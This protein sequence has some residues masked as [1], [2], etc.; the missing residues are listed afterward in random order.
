[1][2]GF[3]SLEQASVAGWGVT[4][5][6]L[7]LQVLEAWHSVA[8]QV[9]GVPAQAPDVQLSLRVQGSLSSQPVPS[10]RFDQ[11]VRALRGLQL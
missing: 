8:V 9:N 2:Q 1:V 6:L 10:T 3:E 5:Q 11:A 4:V 7:P